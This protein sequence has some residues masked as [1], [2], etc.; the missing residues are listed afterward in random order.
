MSMPGFT[1]D[2]S[3]YRTTVPY[4]SAYDRVGRSNLAVDLAQLPLAPDGIGPTNCLP[5]G[6]GCGPD[7]DNPGACC[8]LFRTIECEVICISPCICP[9]PVIC[10]DCLLPTSQLRQPILSGQPIDLATVRFQ[11]T[12]HQ[13][14]TSFTRDC[15]RTSPETRISIPV[16]FVSDKCISVSMGGLDPALINILTRDC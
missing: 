16:P 13:G 1:A 4:Q 3:L 15:T 9:V 14:A 11:Q 6:L 2:T 10:G 8:N 5:R 7:P 12:C